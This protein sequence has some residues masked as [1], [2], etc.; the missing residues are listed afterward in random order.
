ML[1]ANNGPSFYARDEKEWQNI[2]GNN[3]YGF[4]WLLQSYNMNWIIRSCLV[5]QCWVVTAN[6][7]FAIVEQAEQVFKNDAP[8]IELSSMLVTLNYYPHRIW[9]M[10]GDYEHICSYFCQP[11]SLCVGTLLHWLSASVAMKESVRVVVRNI[12]VTD[13]YWRGKTEEVVPLDALWME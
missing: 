10:V 5:C 3:E 12:V 11:F 6:A 1:H 8:N 2:N 4:L 13:Q 7:L 9:E